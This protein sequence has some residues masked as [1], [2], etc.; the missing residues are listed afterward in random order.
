MISPT[1]TPSTGSAL[2]IELFTFVARMTSRYYPAVRNEAVDETLDSTAK[3]K[4]AADP[5][6]ER[7][8]GRL[9][10]AYPPELAVAIDL[11]RER[12]ILGRIPDDA[13]SPPI[14]H[15]TVSRAHFAI[16]W[17]P[18]VR[19]HVGRG[20]GSRNGASIDGVKAELGWQ[21]L[22][23]GSVLRIGDVMLVY[24]LG[25]TLEELD[26]HDVERTAIP[27]DALAIR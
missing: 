9:V 26:A 21:L 22:V 10:A 20:L 24:E 18:S 7:V 19:A 11:A 15:P 4:R 17:D 13:A 23:E 8:L 12:T 5:E 25:H 3:K 27:G 14:Y 2:S 1:S 6:E 16:E